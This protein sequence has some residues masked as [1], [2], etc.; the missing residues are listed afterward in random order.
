VASV[1]PSRLWQALFVTM[2]FMSLFSRKINPERQQQSNRTV[3]ALPYATTVAS[4][5]PVRGKSLQSPL[6]AYSDNSPNTLKAHI[7]FPE[8]V[9]AYW[10]RY[11][12]SPDPTKTSCFS[13]RALL[14]LQPFLCSGTRTQRDRARLRLAAN[15]RPTRLERARGG[16]L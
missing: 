2:G 14:L 6:L 12:G 9:Q 13:P 11:H 5:P 16:T 7:R 1:L 8:M 10:R 3:I 15:Q 4:Q